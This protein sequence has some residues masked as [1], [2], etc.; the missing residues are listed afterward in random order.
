MKNKN[1]MTIS[2]GALKTFDKIQHSFLTKTSQ[3]TRIRKEPSQPDQGHI[4]EKKK[5]TPTVNIILISEILNVFPQDWEQAKDFWS[6][7]FYSTLYRRFYPVNKPRKG[8]K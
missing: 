2:K 4:L 1:H 7:H 6:H 5:I 8:K 3:W